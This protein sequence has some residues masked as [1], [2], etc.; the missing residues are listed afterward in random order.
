MLF[1]LHTAEQAIPH[2]VPKPRISCGAGDLEF[3]RF[4]SI[5]KRLGVQANR[6]LHLIKGAFNPKE[7]KRRN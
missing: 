3:D 1:K 7:T 2:S 6:N 4:N 5:N